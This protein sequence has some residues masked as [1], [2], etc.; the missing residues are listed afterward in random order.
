LHEAVQHLKRG[1]EARLVLP[2]HLAYG[3]AG[4]GNK[5]KGRKSIA[6]VIQISK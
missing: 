2:S 6:M 5:V 3:V 1:A 4:D